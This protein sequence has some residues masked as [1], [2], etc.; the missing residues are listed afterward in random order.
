MKVTDKNKPFAHSSKNGTKF[1]APK[2]DLS[3][4]FDVKI[5]LNLT[6]DLLIAD[7]VE[8]AAYH[9]TVIEPSLSL[10]SGYGGLKFRVQRE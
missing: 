6:E 8:M 9:A 2:K 1:H 10:F 5:P 3:E 4:G 7:V